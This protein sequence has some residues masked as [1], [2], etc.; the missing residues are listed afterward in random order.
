MKSRVVVHQND[1]NSETKDRLQKLDD[2]Y[3]RIGGSVV[4]ESGTGV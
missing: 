3:Y 4:D 1:K 2:E